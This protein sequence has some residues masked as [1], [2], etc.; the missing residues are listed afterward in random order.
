MVQRIVVAKPL[1]ETGCQL[2]EGSLWV[3]P[4]FAL[5]LLRY[6]RGC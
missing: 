1:L 6:A 5:P 2:G 3:S 4:L